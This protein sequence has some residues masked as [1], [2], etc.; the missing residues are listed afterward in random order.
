M[1]NKFVSVGIN[2]YF[3]KMLNHSCHSE[4]PC[5]SERS[6]E[7]VNTP[8]IIKIYTMQKETIK[9]AYSAPSSELLEMTQESIICVSLTPDDITLTEDD[10]V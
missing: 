10:W 3:Y 8:E 4:L 2:L 1:A 6:E 9:Q 7:S 5:H